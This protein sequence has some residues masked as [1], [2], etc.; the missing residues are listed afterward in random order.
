MKLQI[1]EPNLSKEEQLLKDIQD[2]FL[3]E[4]PAFTSIELAFAALTD[5]C[6]QI[7]K[8]PTDDKQMLKPLVLQVRENLSEVLSNLVDQFELQFKIVQASIEVESSKAAL[9]SDADVSQEQSLTPVAIDVLDM[10]NSKKPYK[11]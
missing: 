4:Q 5:L 9:P 2:F 1:V 6:V 3:A 11:H 8:L 10:D 7:E